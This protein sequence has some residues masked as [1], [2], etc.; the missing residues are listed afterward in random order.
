MSE[1]TTATFRVGEDDDSAITYEVSKFSDE[2]KQAFAMLI[3]INKECAALQLRLSV[4]NMS[5]VGFT[6]VITDQLSEDMQVASEDSE[7]TE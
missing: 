6:K 1:E 3:E 4:L 7:A 2:G 5:G